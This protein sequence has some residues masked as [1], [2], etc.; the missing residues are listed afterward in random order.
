MTA[1]TV[2]FELP[3]VMKLE[4]CQGLHAF[5]QDAHGKP[6]TLECAAVT[7]I[8]GLAGQMILMA[9]KSWA[10]DNLQ[11]DLNAPSEGCIE[12]LKILGMDVLMTDAEN[13]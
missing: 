1:E 7:R 4:D 12:S 11:F 8:T 2:C 3:P 13:A 10:A 6:V 5:L 9:Q